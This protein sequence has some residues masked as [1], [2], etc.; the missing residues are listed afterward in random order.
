MKNTSFCVTAANSHVPAQSLIYMVENQYK[1]PE[2]KG[3]AGFIAFAPDGSFL[4]YS[5]SILD[6]QGELKSM[7]QNFEDD[8]QEILS[9]GG[10]WFCFLEH[11]LVNGLQVY[12]STNS[13]IES[14]DLGA[15]REDCQ[16][17]PLTR[18]I[19]RSGENLP[20][21]SLSIEDL[22]MYL[23]NTA[24]DDEMRLHLG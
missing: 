9:E 8:Y 21:N 15:E 18:R 1:M 2:V 14:F 6:L 13:A 22:Y 4:A 5:R 19:W 3:Y 7:F 17:C 20:E 12:L 23:V 10:A 11:L 16:F 24:T